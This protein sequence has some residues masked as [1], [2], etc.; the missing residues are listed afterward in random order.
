MNGIYLTGLVPTADEIVLIEGTVGK[1]EEGHDTQEIQGE[2]KARIWKGVTNW[3][4]PV[5]VAILKMVTISEF[6]QNVL[7]LR[8]EELHP[9]LVEGMGGAG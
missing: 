6:D 1:D 3:G 8:L 5:E 7:T 9:E 2:L 4:N